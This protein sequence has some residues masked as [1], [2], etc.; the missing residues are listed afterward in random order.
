MNLL[1]LSVPLAQE[2]GVSALGLLG[3]HLLAAIVFSIVG[4]VVFTICLYTIEKVTP[5]SIMKEIEEEHNQAMAMI[6]SAIV[7][8]IS[9]IIAAAILG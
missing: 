3:A 2:E 8:G 7:L 4:I 1:E 6:V 5:F 9:I